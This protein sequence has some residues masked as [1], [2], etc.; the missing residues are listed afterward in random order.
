MRDKNT[1]NDLVPFRDK[2]ALSRRIIKGGLN[3]GEYVIFY[4]TGTGNSLAVAINIAKRLGDTQLV[5]IS[6][7]IKSESF[8]LAG[9]RIGFVFPS[10]YAC[11]PS[12]VRN[13]ISGVDFSGTE[14][15]FGVVTY[16]ASYGMALAQLSQAITERGGVLNA[17]FS[18]HMPGNYIDSYGA[19]PLAIQRIV[20]NGKAKKVEKIVSEIKMNGSTR[21]PKGSIIQ[22]SFEKKDL[23]ILDSFSTAAKNFHTNEKCTGCGICEKICPVDN[24]ML[25]DGHP[26]WGDKCEHCVACIQWCP[27]L[28]IEYAD[29]T[30]KRSHYHNPEV[31][32]SD[33]SQL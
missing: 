30:S 7:A 6:R 13:F 21:I 33:L 5:S 11:M 12:I 19:W 16:G 18:V 26:V 4:F 31:T 3:S 32:L 24:I 29:K 14:Y 1:N 25:L 15:L 22:R 20:L 23:E 2:Y 17:A 8:D 9:K 10:Y 28:A 27:Q